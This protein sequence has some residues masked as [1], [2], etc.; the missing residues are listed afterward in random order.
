M[1]KW[2]YSIRLS[3]ENLSLAQDWKGTVQA[4]KSRRHAQVVEE[5][6]TA[7]SIKSDQL[8]IVASVNERV[9]SLKMPCRLRVSGEAWM[10]MNKGH[11]SRLIE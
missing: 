9:T 1:S 11:L 4:Q 2:S 8:N 5:L 7:R 3:G 10:T 6:W